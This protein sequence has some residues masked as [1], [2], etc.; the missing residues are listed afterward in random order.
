[1]R[2]LT[3]DPG[4][5]FGWAIFEDGELDAYGKINPRIEDWQDRVEK[6]REM[7]GVEVIHQFRFIHKIYIERPVYMP[8]HAA[9]DSDSLVKLCMTVGSFMSMCRVYGHRVEFIRVCDWLGQMSDKAIRHR[10]EGILGKEVTDAIPA[11]AI[12]ATGMGLYVLGKWPGGQ[13]FLEK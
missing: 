11:H 2:M 6:A 5:P 3:I 7:L 10:V 9:A 4:V 1:M 8:G 12:D 13:K